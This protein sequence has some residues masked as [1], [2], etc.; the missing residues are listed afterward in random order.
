MRSCRATSHCQVL[1]SAGFLV[2]LLENNK[3]Q[4]LDEKFHVWCHLLIVIITGGNVISDFFRRRLKYAEAGYSRSVI[5]SLFEVRW[6][7]RLM[8]IRS[9]KG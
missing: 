5:I 6:E 8:L 7:T 3:F 2:T 1:D 4:G 9:K